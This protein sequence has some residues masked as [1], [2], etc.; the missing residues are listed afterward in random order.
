MGIAEKIFKVKVIARQSALLRWRHTFPRRGV[1]ARLL[2]VC[3]YFVFFF[4]SNTQPDVTGLGLYQLLILCRRMQLV[5]S[6]MTV[7][8][9]WLVNYRDV[10][11]PPTT[12]P[13]SVV[14]S[15]ARRLSRARAGPSH[16]LGWSRP[17]P[18]RSCASPCTTSPSSRPPQVRAQICITTHPDTVLPIRVECKNVA[19]VNIPPKMAANSVISVKRCWWTVCGCKYIVVS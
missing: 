17:A 6:L 9:W 19:T 14:S 15:P 1:E 2:P 8:Q 13:V 7:V 12:T 16:L 5:R 11:L 3:H 10:E 18:V 4:L